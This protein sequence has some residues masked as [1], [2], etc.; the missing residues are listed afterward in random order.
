[1]NMRKRLSLFGLF[2]LPALFGAVAAFGQ[3]AIG[4]QFTRTGTE[5]ASITTTAVDENGTPLNSVTAELTSSH[6]FKATTTALT[7]SIICPDANGNTNPTI[8]LTL[9]V[10]GLPDGYAFNKVGLDIHAFN[11]AGAYQS[12]N[13]GKSRRFNVDVKGGNG[14]GEA[15][16]DIGQLSDIDIAAGVG[17]K[18]NVHKVWDVPA[19]ET[20][21]ASGGALTLQLTV[22]TGSDNAGCFFGLSAITIGT[23]ATAAEMPEAGKFYYIKWNKSAGMYM[24]QEAD[25][26]LVVKG[27]DVAQRQFWQFVPTG[28]E[29]CWY[30]QNA[31]SGLYVQSCN[32]AAGS[33]SLVKAG[34][35]P[36]EYFVSKTTSADLNG[37]YRLTSTDCANYADTSK[38]PLGLNKDGASSNIIVW[39]AGTAQAGSWWQLEETENLFDL[40]PFE[41]SSQPGTPLYS[42]AIISSST[43]KALQMAADGTLSWAERTDGD[44][45]AWYFVGTGNNNG[46]FLIANVGTGKTVAAGDASDARWYVLEAGGETGGYQ[47]RPFDTRDDASTTLT[48][49]DAAGTVTFSLL[50]SRF[51]RAAQVYEMPC[52]ALGTLYVKSAGISGD[53]AVETMDY[54]LPVLSGHEISTPTASAPSTWYTLWTQDKATVTAGRSFDLQVTLSGSPAT[55]DAVYAYF[56]WNRDGVFEDAHQLTFNGSTMTEK[57][58]VPASAKA[59]KARL[60]L[61]LTANGL[62]GAEDEVAGQIIDFV[63]NITTETTEQYT[64]TA[65]PNDKT[66]GSVEIDGDGT[67]T[68]VTAIPRGNATFVCWREGNVPVSA[69]TVYS[70]A[71]DHNTYLTAVFSPNTDK[72]STAIEPDGLTEQSLLVKVSGD[73]R[74]INVQ[75]DGVVKR[76]LVYDA[77]GKLVARSS[78]KRVKCTGVASGT[79]IVKV[80]TATTDIAQKI[81]LE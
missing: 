36:V 73:R 16:T 2:C 76:V 15:L 74:Y 48:A 79:Y 5:A 13:D 37:A 59:G 80:Y 77:A 69:Q 66:R 23:T 31:A 61:R 35:N 62:S 71:P 52:G 53:G 8:V 58:D 45:Q 46:G 44:D 30:I 49:G 20:V 63:L 11:G 42:Y 1:M 65:V 50:H 24:T 18:D 72:T 47:F 10:K 40:R 67:E 60:R 7:Q 17:T 12:N 14:I 56:D 78:D 32:K 43:G 29:N 81:I 22:T 64:V 68:T 25:G 27:Q 34:E 4:F 21:S 33:A 9:S 26:A 51:A 6:T 55:G 28:K 54:P 70:F 57:I 41:F 38:E 3:S 75:T 39:Q 19:A